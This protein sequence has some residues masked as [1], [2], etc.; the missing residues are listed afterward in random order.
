MYADVGGMRRNEGGGGVRK[1]CIKPAST[2]QSDV[3]QLYEHLIASSSPSFLCNREPNKTNHEPLFNAYLNFLQA[4]LWKPTPYL[5][6]L[7]LSRVLPY[8]SFWRALHAF[9]ATWG[10]IPLHLLP[11]TALSLCRPAPSPL[12]RQGGLHLV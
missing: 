8:V 11:P 4:H 9:N 10:C 1:M 6:V 7:L 2:P 12:L 3:L 5:H